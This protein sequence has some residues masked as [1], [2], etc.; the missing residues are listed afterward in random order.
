MRSFE[1][2]DGQAAMRHF[3]IK[4]QVGMTD[5][6]NLAVAGALTSSHQSSIAQALGETVIVAI[7]YGAFLAKEGVL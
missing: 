6:V 3:G 5:A 2:L 7:I 1:L 4:D